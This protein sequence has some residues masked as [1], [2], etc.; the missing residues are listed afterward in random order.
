[1]PSQTRFATASPT[2]DANNRKRA[3]RYESAH[4]RIDR[5]FSEDLTE[6]EAGIP[7]SNASPAAAGSLRPPQNQRA[8][9]RIMVFNIEGALLSR[10]SN[11]IKHWILFFGLPL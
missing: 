2:N 9:V 6:K 10:L 4:D 1:M 8:K 7:S 3:S 11:S 5:S